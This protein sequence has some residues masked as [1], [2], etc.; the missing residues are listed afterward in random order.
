MP[1][2]RADLT[3]SEQKFLMD[4]HAR[5]FADRNGGQDLLRIGYHACQLLGGGVVKGVV[6]NTIADEFPPSDPKRDQDALYTVNTAWVDLCPT[7]NVP[8]M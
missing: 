8:G 4:L 3:L 5:G 6:V 2:A 7:L 1:E